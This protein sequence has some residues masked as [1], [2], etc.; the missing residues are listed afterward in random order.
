MSGFVIRHGEHLLAFDL[1]LGSQ[2]DRQYGAE[3]PMWARPTFSYARPVDPL[4][5]QFA[6]AGQPLPEEVLLSHSHWDHGS[7]LEDIPKARVWVSGPEL[8]LI[9][10]SHGGAGQPW[11][12]Q[13]GRPDI[14][15]ETLTF[16]DGPWMGFDR[17]LD[18]FGDKSVVVVPMPGHTPGSVGLFV[19]VD[20]YLT[21][22]SWADAGM[23]LQTIM[24]AAKGL[25]LDTCPQAAWSSCGCGR[26]RCMASRPTRWWEPPSRPRMNCGERR[27]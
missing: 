8:D 22:G 20:S 18:V 25:G 24:L 2:I 16:P 10:A 4:A 13:V 11:M 7:G 3:M 1:G 6:R 19:T 21:R 12:S 27:R 5:A 23:Y 9:R 15:W 17:S 14:R 26:T